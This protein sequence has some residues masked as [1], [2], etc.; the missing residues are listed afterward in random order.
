MYGPL[1]LGSTTLTRS[2]TVV[3]GV[4]GPAEREYACPAWKDAVYRC[5]MVV[6]LVIESEKVGEESRSPPS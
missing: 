3:G 6:M 4:T 1:A 2:R 5:A